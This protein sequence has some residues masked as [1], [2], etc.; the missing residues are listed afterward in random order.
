MPDCWNVSD[1]VSRVGRTVDIVEDRCANMTDRTAFLKRL[2]SGFGGPV[3]EEG[4][5][6]TSTVGLEIGELN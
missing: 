5:G 6:G 4:V 2:T 1:V 3:S